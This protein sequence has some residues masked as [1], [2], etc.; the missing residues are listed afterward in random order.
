MY[1]YA[2]IGGGIVGL[3]AAWQLKQ[4]LPEAS[5]V[6]IEKEAA[7]S[8]HQTG[9][10][11]GVIHAGI[12]YPPDSLKARLC[13]EGVTTTIEFCEEHGVDY[14]QCGKL[15]VATHESE[16]D[17]LDALYERAKDNG[18]NI[19]LIDGAAAGELE[20]NITAVKALLSP[21]TGI[22]DYPG[23]CRAM[24]ASFERHGGELRLGTGV[25]AMTETARHIEIR[26]NTGG[27][28]RAGY[29]IAC[30]GLMADRLAA[31]LDVKADFRV[32]PFRGAYYGL[33]A[34]HNDIIK[35]LI[36]PVPNPELPFL[37]V[38]L[39]RMIDGSVTVGPTACLSFKREGYG[40]INIS[41]RD[42]LSMLSY[43][44]TWRLLSQHV[45]PGLIEL[46]NAFSKRSFL[47]Q[48]RRYA[49]SLRKKDLKPWP[50]GVRAQAIDT[51]GNMIHDFLFADTPRSL[52]VCNAPSPAATSA[53][54]IGR[55]IC[56][57]VIG[58]SAD[59]L[60]AERMSA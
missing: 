55:T 41:V 19:E 58:Q 6:L 27:T 13:R 26:T 25:S 5:I 1:D 24:A 21:K 56:E 39:T 11:S 31:M 43:P 54:P 53:I 22:V 48:I 49:P 60:A 38:H 14:E 33:D 52:H 51:Q 18:L 4:R 23:M 45:G 50:T 12:Y 47:K 36:Y 40:K 10:N 44:G 32:V 46:R 29:V 15:I 2:I 34:R 7:V 8:M 42:S 20:P 59:D 37:G 16:I 35:H 57:R 17:R 3:S 28:I 9:R 30:G